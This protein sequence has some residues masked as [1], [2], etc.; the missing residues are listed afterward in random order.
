MSPIISSVNQSFG[1]ATTS[2]KIVTNGLVLYLDAGQSTSY[3]G[4]ST[5]TDLSGQGNNGSLVNGPTYNSSNGGYIAFDGV[6]DRCVISVPELSNQEF[7]ADFFIYPTANSGV[8][9]LETIICKFHASNQW[10][11][12]LAIGAF[13]TV[14]RTLGV[15]VRDRN[16]NSAGTTGGELNLNQWYHITFS[17]KELDVIKLYLDGSLVGT[18]ST[19]TFSMPPNITND[20]YVCSSDVSIDGSRFYGGMRISNFRLY[21]KVISAQEVQKNF[22]ALRGRFGI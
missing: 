21:N 6:N 20:V 3:N 14:S 8:N 11:F 2:P 10:N 17:I 15:S 13:S 7:S 12:R 19:M 22:N 1:F 4:G 5:W 16:N 18:S 9:D